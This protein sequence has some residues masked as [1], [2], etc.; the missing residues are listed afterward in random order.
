V[1]QSDAWMGGS[2]EKERASERARNRPPRKV[3]TAEAGRSGRVSIPGPP[4]IERFAK[5]RGQQKTVSALALSWLMSVVQDEGE[6]ERT[7][8]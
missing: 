8:Q 1:L 7:D 3:R 4:G 2:R 5:R 6:R